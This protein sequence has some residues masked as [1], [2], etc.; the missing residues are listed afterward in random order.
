MI[1]HVRV[2]ALLGCALV[3]AC[4]S[5]GGEADPDETGNTG[6]SPGG[7]SAGNVADMDPVTGDTGGGEPLAPDVDAGVPVEP[8]ASL[9]DAPVDA[10]TQPMD[11][12]L[13]GDCE[14][15]F[16]FDPSG[17][18]DV[19]EVA[20]T[21]DYSGWLPWVPSATRGAIAM[22]RGPDGRY[23][24]R[25]R[26]YKEVFRY[27]FVI[28]GDDPAARWVSDPDNCHDADDSFGGRNS[29]R[30]ACQLPPACPEDE[31]DAGMDGSVV[32]DD[33]D[34][35]HDDDA[36]DGEDDE[37]DDDAGDG[38]D[39]E[40]DAGSDAGSDE[41]ATDAG[42]LDP[43]GGADENEVD[44]VLGSDCVEVFEVDPALYPEIEA[45]ETVELRGEAP[46]SYESAI[47]ALYEEDDGIWRARASVDAA[48]FRYNVVI[49]GEYFRD[50]DYCPSANDGLGGRNASLRSTCSVPACCE[51][52]EIAWSP[53][54]SGC[55]EVEAASFVGQLARWDAPGIPMTLGE[56]GVF[57]ITFRDA[58]GS[59]EYKVWVDGAFLGAFDDN[60]RDEGEPNFRVDACID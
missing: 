35:G 53:E 33:E 31:L 17:Y 52:I 46:L 14:E 40:D 43:D 47:V 41:G 10:G 18:D 34:A 56:D 45:F 38:D 48:T 1:R 59:Y 7:S 8:D 4:G 37:S 44:V 13:E 22:Q 28:N 20:L 15:V 24:A 54:T 19:R 5:D 12:G 58:P 32:E 26:L 55:G 42:A 3:S 49:N 50:R 39:G 51:A 27:K 60:C 16:A 21:G 30:Y 29:V 6:E 36:G 11:A 2:L 57:R 23:Y 25:L 9:P